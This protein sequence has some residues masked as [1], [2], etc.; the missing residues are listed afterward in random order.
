MIFDVLL[1][2]ALMILLWRARW[3]FEPK[4]A[5]NNDQAAA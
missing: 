5:H 4:A 1:I 2:A 3:A